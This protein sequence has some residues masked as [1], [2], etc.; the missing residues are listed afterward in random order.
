MALFDRLNPFLKKIPEALKTGASFVRQEAEAQSA[1]RNVATVKRLRSGEVSDRP[2][3]SPLTPKQEFL[4]NRAARQEEIEAI[5]RNPRLSL[6]Q[7]AFQRSKL[8]IGE[9]ARGV[10]KGSKQAAGFGRDVARSVA[11]EAGGVKLQIQGKDKFTPRTGLQKFVFGEES[12]GTT[13]EQGKE[14]LEGF[15]ISAEKAKKFGFLA[16]GL[17][18][19]LNFIPGGSASKGVDDIAKTV[20]KGSASKTVKSKATKDIAKILIKDVGVDKKVA[21]NLAP[22]LLAET[23]PKI[24]SSQ[25]KKAFEDPSSVLRGRPGQNIITKADVIKD[26]KAGIS[27]SVELTPNVVR[28]KVVSQ[29]FRGDKLNLA[30]AELVGIEQRLSALGLKTREV[31][32]FKQMEEAAL[33]LGVDPGQLLKE[34]RANRITDKEVVG[35]R[36]LINNNSEFI[37][38]SEGLIDDLGKR[39]DDPSITPATRDAIE[40]E[41]T[42]LRSRVAQSSAQ[43]DTALG[44]LVKGGTEAGR[45]V[46]SFRILANKTLEPS[47]WLAKAKRMA[48]KEQLSD[49]AIK[50]ITKLAQDKDRIGLATFV[51]MMR[52]PGLSEQAVTLWKAGLLTSPTTHLAN[53]GGNVTM[54]IL[55]TASDVAST[56]FDVIAGLFTGKR[57]I[58]I[59]PRTVS[60]KIKGLGKGT[61]KAKDFFKTGVY[62]EEILTKYDI[63]RQSVFKNKILKG[64]TETV[65]RSLGAEDIL[66]R[67]AAIAESL[68]KGAIITAKNEGL[69]GNLLKTRVGELLQNPTN[70]MVKESIDAAEYATFQNPNALHD[71]IAG[72]KGAVRKKS[73]LATSVL[74]VLAPF[75]KTPTNIA[76]RIADFSPLGFVKAIFKVAKPSTR[77]QK[78]F[79]QDLGRATTGTGVIALGGYLSKKGLMTGN[80]PTNPKERAQFFA[81]GKQPNSIRI[82]DRWFNLGRVSPVGN[83]LSL[84]AEFNELG[85]TKEGFDLIQATGAAG[86]KGLTE[87]TFLKGV[88]G[89]L[90]A[91]TDPEREAGTFVEQS[92]ASTIPSIISRAAR[93]KDPKLRLSEGV[94]QKIQERL[95][96]L[97]E[98]LPV[99]RDI[100]GKEVDVPG[101]RL[102]LV[103]PFSTTEATDNPV[104]DEAKELGISIGMPSQTISKTKLTEKEYSIYQGVQGQLLEAVLTELIESEEYK[105]ATNTQ[106][107]ELFAAE[108]RNL[109]SELNDQ[110]FPSLMIAR[111]D[112]P[113]ETNKDLL[114]E[115]M[116]KLNSKDKFKNASEDKQAEV[117]KLLLEEL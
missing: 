18:F 75:T 77:S 29:K 112:L 83:L 71:L 53:I 7:K 106:K 70:Q 82:G 104:I 24:I 72:A 66:F 115:L 65:F 32:T 15:G 47:F 95:P 101:G 89:G 57:T 63:P 56:G 50:A 43:V 6:A 94:L 69:S 37:A 80:I 96:I 45:T 92:I 39:L 98:K 105:N 64:Y 62:P 38:K 114:R 109:R 55:N 84:G 90:K 5:N 60:A 25:I 13:E 30:E 111:Y 27:P 4:L 20:V 76:A 51:S 42:G 22:R 113:K 3:I 26:A 107:E 91:V 16:G 34:V 31:R 21:G 23:D 1:E 28:K 14:L 54:G 17:S 88:S 59:T 99:R 10:S 46:A 78:A 103:D 67:E 8:S 108:Q 86:V 35:L 73:P 102:N 116:S 81:E 33:E 41:L 68:E 2:S 87:Q 52:K 40:N 61:K 49:D 79:V 11:R 117:I 58:T 12:F 97:R 19:G 9:K 100:F 44:K 110:L 85:E 74:E 93:T 36:N 48:G